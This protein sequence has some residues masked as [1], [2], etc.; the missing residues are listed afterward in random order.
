MTGIEPALLVMSLGSQP[1]V[2]P[3]DLTHHATSP[4]RY[5]VPTS[6]ACALVVVLFVS[7]LSSPTL[8]LVGTTVSVGLG[9]VKTC[10]VLRVSKH[11]IEGSL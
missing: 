1:S 7:A 2:L 5:R 8:G 9:L 3:F 10:L 4:T 6:R 11:D